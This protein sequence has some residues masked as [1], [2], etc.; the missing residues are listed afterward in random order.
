[1]SETT[2]GPVVCGYDGSRDARRAVAWAAAWARDHGTS[3][4]VISADRAVGRVVAFDETARANVEGAM[5]D[6]L[7]DLTADVPTTHRVIADSPVS[8]LVG[9]G[10]DASAIVVGSRG[11][12][13]REDFAMG[14][15]SAGVVEHATCPVLVIT[16]RTPE[17]PTGGPV[18][19]AADGS[20]ASDPAVA[21]AFAEAERR[22]V[23]L[24]AVHSVEVPRLPGTS[25]FDLDQLAESVLAEDEKDILDSLAPHEARHPEV[26]VELILVVGEPAVTVADEATGASLLVTGSRG[27]G[28]FAGLLLGSVSRR[29]LQTAPCAVA[30]VRPAD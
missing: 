9:V 7:A 28:G 15:T 29:L 2:T 20:A 6:Q 24:R 17:S 11:L 23:T 1:M 10:R 22:G 3:L 8:A 30:V 21:F 27:H 5:R 12:T 14:S 18:V 25:L 13:A 4:E 19:L 26:S 16:P